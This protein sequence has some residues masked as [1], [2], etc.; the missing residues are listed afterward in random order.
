MKASL[1]GGD[2]VFYR[3]WEYG[4]PEKVNFYKSKSSALIVTT[5]LTGGLFVS[6]AQ[7]LGGAQIEFF[8]K[9]CI[10]WGFN[11]DV[12]FTGATGAGTTGA[13]GSTGLAGVGF[14][15]ATGTDGATG[16]IGATGAG[17]SDGYIIAQSSIKGRSNAPYT[18]GSGY[19]Y[20]YSNST[21]VLDPASYTGEGN[22]LATQNTTSF[23]IAKVGAFN[24]FG[25]TRSNQRK[26]RLTA[27]ATLMASKSAQ[28]LVNRTLHWIV[29]RATVPGA[30]TPF[31]TATFTT[32]T[33]G[34]GTQTNAPFTISTTN[35][36]NFQIDV[37]FATVA[38]DRHDLV[39]VGV[40]FSQISGDLDPGE[41]NWTSTW[42]LTDEGIAT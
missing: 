38:F 4:Q 20:G 29:L 40:A 12:G 36:H 30:N 28:P 10:G 13:Q 7:Y 14:I 37:E 18:A 31:T 25:V 19:A 1:I 21:S 33:A 16:A 23:S 41:W 32:S 17:T 11:G 27:N 22:L 15:G 24:Q 2:Q 5:G 39:A 9:P 6:K 26:L 8:N 42:K 34:S 3:V 35:G